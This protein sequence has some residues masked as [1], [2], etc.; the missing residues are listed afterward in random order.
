MADENVV[1]LP[2]LL[3]RLADKLRADVAL[4][5]QGQ[6]QW[7]E[8]TLAM[9]QHL[10]EAREVFGED[11]RAFGAWL[12]REQIQ[13]ERDDRQALINFGENMAKFRKILSDDRAGLRPNTLWQKNKSSYEKFVRPKSAKQPPSIQFEKCKDAYADLKLEGITPT[14]EAV[15]KRAG[16][17]DTPARIAVAFMHGTEEARPLTDDERK[18]R[19]A[20]FEKRYE[21]TLKKARAEIRDEL[22]AEVYKEL[23]VFVRHVKERAER[24]DRILAGFKG[25]MSKET[26]RKIRAC[27]HPDHNTFKFAAEALQA[28]S[29]LEAVLVKPDD[30]VYAGPPLPTTAAELMARRRR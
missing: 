26:F 27:L 30:P 8:A 18:L 3:E 14:V 17:S 20:A 21:A 13:I 16:T 12:K 1:Q 6:K 10:R 19:G 4:A 24:A 7:I 2:T 9:A 22:R 29:E 5:D 23:D 25:H 11:D 28:F 15:A